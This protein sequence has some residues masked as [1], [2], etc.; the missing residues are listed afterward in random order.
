MIEKW[1]K[2]VYARDARNEWGGKVEE[3]DPR[4]G[5]IVGGTREVLGRNK[6]GKW[7]GGRG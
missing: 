5:L 2:D 1:R 7:E 3:R 4:D 6:G